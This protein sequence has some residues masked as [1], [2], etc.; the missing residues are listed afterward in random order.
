M[1]L[2]LVFVLG[3]A[4]FAANKAVLESGHSM[5]EELPRFLRRWDGRMPLA[6]E[7][8]VLLA[9]MLLVANGWP[10]V[11]WAYAAYSLFTL[12]SAWAIL[13]GRI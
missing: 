10:A 5:L 11:A 4:N 8:A 12:A 7:F 1:L 6:A 9:A 13:T 2:A 3:M